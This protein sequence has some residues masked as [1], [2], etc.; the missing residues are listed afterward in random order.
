MSQKKAFWSTLPGILTGTATVITAAIALFGTLSNSGKNGT[1]GAPAG[2]PAASVSPETVGFGKQ[3]LIQST[4]Q[5]VTVTNSGGSDLKIGKV[6]IAGEG[7]G[8]F[9]VVQDTCASQLLAPG[10]RCQINIRFAPGSLGSFLA[11]L[12]IGHNARGNPTMVPL[13]GEAILLQL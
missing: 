10:S 2:E 3:G 9:R 1:G 13:S 4:P 12:E 8:V 5:A 11:T 7:K 6:G